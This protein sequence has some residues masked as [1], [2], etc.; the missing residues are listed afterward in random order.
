MLPNKKPEMLVTLP[1][2]IWATYFL[3]RLKNAH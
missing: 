2:K 3:I 1:V